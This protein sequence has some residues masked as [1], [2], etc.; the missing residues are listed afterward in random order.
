MKPEV[1]ASG[2]ILTHMTPLP[3]A[4]TM[5]ST[6]TETILCSQLADS[7]D[8]NKPR[9]PGPDSRENGDSHAN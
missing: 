6:A 7:D 5:T 9:D 2:R 4:S 8:R 3:S 1:L